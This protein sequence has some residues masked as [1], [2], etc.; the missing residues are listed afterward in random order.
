MKLSPFGYTEFILESC[1]TL[2]GRNEYPSDRFLR[3][4]VQYQRCLEEVRDSI[5]KGLAF[6][7]GLEGAESTIAANRRRM[8]SLKRGSAF[9]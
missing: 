4:I 7:E 6:A 9:H 8:D 3:Y 1:Y 2:E 5:P